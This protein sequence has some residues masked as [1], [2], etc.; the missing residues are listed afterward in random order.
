ML[1]CSQCPLGILWLIETDSLPLID[2]SGKLTF[3]Q[4]QL[5]PRQGGKPLIAGQVFG[6]E[7]KGEELHSVESGPQSVRL[8]AEEI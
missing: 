2:A 4:W 3:Q 5:N 1:N 6:E 8:A 7:R